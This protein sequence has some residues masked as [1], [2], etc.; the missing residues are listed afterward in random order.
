MFT[1]FVVCLLAGPF[2]CL[3]SFVCGFVF[4]CLFVCFCARCIM[5]FLLIVS[6]FGSKLCLLAVFSFE[7]VGLGNRLRGRQ[8]S[9]SKVG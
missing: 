9:S 3:H 2:V 1:G 5:V 7:D 8:L 6:F 4:V